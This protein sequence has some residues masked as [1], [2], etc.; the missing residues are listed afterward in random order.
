VFLLIHFDRMYTGMS[1]APKEKVK[2]RI[3]HF[4]FPQFSHVPKV[5]VRRGLGS[6][7]LEILHVKKQNPKKTRHTRF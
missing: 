2:V 5:E 1:A 6:E 4:F 7:E 3:L